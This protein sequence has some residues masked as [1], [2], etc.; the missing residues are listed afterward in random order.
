MIVTF[1]EAVRDDVPRIVAL[2]TDDVLGQ[3]R[4]TP[5]TAIKEAAFDDIASGSGIDQRSPKISFRTF[6]ITRSTAFSPVRLRWLRSVATCDDGSGAIIG[7]GRTG[8]PS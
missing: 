3:G 7:S 1:R 6:R 4:E 5:E 8:T 2:L